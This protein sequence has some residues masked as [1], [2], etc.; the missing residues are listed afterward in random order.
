MQ[1]VQVRGLTLQQIASE[2]LGV[3]DIGV[4][5]TP[6]EQSQKVSPGERQ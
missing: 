3:R 6:V 5:T 4:E 2:G 1:G